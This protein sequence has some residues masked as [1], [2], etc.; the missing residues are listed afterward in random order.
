MVVLSCVHD[1]LVSQL[2]SG[3][4]IDYPDLDLSHRQLFANQTW[5]LF[6]IDTH[7]GGHTTTSSRCER[8]ISLHQ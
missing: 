2:S 8:D 4:S 5:K 6:G 1:G 7:Y 3:S